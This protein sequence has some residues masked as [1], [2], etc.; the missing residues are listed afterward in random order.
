MA[1]VHHFL[2]M[3][4]GIQNLC[5]TQKESGAQK[6]HMTAVS[7]ISDMEE[8]FNTFWLLFQ[9]DGAA[10]VKLRDRSQLPPALS[11]KDLPGK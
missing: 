1:K 8:I 2:E 6:K 5:G 3:W 11:A 4:H 9:H 10:A 7:Y